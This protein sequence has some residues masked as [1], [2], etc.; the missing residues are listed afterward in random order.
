MRVPDSEGVNVVVTET[1]TETSEDSDE[2]FDFVLDPTDGVNVGES[3]CVDEREVVYVMDHDS[4]SVNSSEGDDDGDAVS[5]ADFVGSRVFEYESVDVQVA[6]VVGST[7]PEAVG[8][9]D[10][11]R[12]RVCSRVSDSECVHERLFVS[13]GVVVDDE[14]TLVVSVVVA[15]D[16]GVAVPV[17]DGDEVAVTPWVIGDRE[18]VNVTEEE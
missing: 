17:Q 12:D 14:E 3:V 8:D 4:D 15:L 11:V 18:V 13:L 1:V 6:D 5:V 9:G 16:V 10:A 2:D 7:V